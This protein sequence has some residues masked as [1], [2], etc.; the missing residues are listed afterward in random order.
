MLDETLGWCIAP[1]LP[2]TWGCAKPWCRQ[3]WLSPLC[4]LPGP[5]K[6]D[7]H[8]GH[9]QHRPWGLPGLLP[10]PG[11]VDPAWRLLQRAAAESAREDVQVSSWQGVSLHIWVKIAV[12]WGVPSMG[13]TVLRPGCVQHFSFAP[14]TLAQMGG[15]RRSVLLDTCARNVSCL[16]R[17]V[18][19]TSVSL[20]SAGAWWLSGWDTGTSGGLWAAEMGKDRCEQPGVAW[21]SHPRCCPHVPCVPSTGL[22]LFSSS[23]H[24]RLASAVS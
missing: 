3:H 20:E 5:A 10:S 17:T 14:P 4:H 2:P 24:C 18:S 1:Y 8:A 9:Q 15:W 21:Q 7:Q 11:R 12:E 13:I 6:E 23:S 19:I 22:E 16:S